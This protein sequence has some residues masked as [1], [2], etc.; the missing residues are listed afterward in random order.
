M[1]NEKTLRI[2]RFDPEN[3]EKGSYYRSYTVAAKPGMT[4]LEAL[5]DV[6]DKQD[7]TLAFRYSCR[8][9]ICGS[10][11]MTL[12]GKCRLACKTQISDYKGTLTIEPLPGLDIIKDLVVDLEPFFDNYRRIKPYLIPKAVPDRENIQ[13]PEDVKL[14][15]PH[16]KCIL[17]AICEAS[18]PVSWTSREKYLGPMALTKVYRFNRDTRDAGAKERLEIVGDE[19]GVWRCR[20]IFR[21]TEYCP[22]DIPITEAIQYLKRRYFR[23]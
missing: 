5:F 3:P 17:C 21:C 11:G 15:D 9:A 2:F 6:L 7:G 20:T 18:C 23:D 12:N 8:W 22:K 4:V 19:T 1:K 10:C 14:I 13:M 16:I